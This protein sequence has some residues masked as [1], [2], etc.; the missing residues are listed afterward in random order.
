MTIFYRLRFETSLFVA[1][2]DSQGHGGGIRTRLHTGVV[3]DCPNFLPYNYF[4]TDRTENTVFNINSIVACEFVVRGTCLPSRC[5][6]MHV[7]S[8]STIPSFRRHDTVWKFTS[9]LFYYRLYILKD[10]RVLQSQRQ[11][12]NKFSFYKSANSFSKQ[13]ANSWPVIPV[14]TL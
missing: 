13:L 11:I 9:S 3:T 7:S 5:L 8:G 4:C 1:S 6:A 12:S 14:V 2:Y 10:D